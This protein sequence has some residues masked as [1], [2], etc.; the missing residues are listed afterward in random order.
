[1]SVLQIDKAEHACS[2]LIFYV[3]T[4]FFVRV[5]KILIAR[6]E[7][8]NLFFQDFI[9]QTKFLSTEYIFDRNLVYKIKS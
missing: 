2:V 3:L 5:N 1:M 8:M 4:T 6:R 9:L 7:I